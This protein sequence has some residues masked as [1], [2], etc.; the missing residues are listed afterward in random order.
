[1]RNKLQPLRLHYITR[2]STLVKMFGMFY[3][4]LFSVATRPV[5][6]NLHS[7]LFSNWT[8]TSGLRRAPP[9]SR[10][11]FRSECCDGG[12]SVAAPRMYR[13]L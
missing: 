1:M 13:S 3:E 7:L 5:Q 10:G 12:E 8:D 2:S 6:F 11:C 4:K 9:S